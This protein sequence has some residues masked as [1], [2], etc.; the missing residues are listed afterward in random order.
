MRRTTSIAWRALFQPKPTSIIRSKSSPPAR[1]AAATS[2]TSSSAERPR[3][4]QPSLTALKPASRCAATVRAAAS[5]VS[6]I[7]VLAY[8]FT[9]SRRAP[10]TSAWIGLPDALPTIS[11]RAI[12]MPLMA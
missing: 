1:R 8:A 4:P 12:S 6:G 11:H 3:G 9:R 2:A 10:P 7:S 5:G